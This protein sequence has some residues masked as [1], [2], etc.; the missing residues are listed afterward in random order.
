MTD[1]LC[2]ETNCIWYK[3]EECDAG[4]IVVSCG[5]CRTFQDYI[6]LPEYQCEYWEAIVRKSKKDIA[7]KRNKGKE[8]MVNDVKF[9]TRNNMKWGERC[10]YLTDARTG[11]MVG[12]MKTL[13]ERWDFYIDAI[14]KHRDVMEFPEME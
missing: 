5:E 14:K 9:Y 12:D 13:K 1:I 10:I 11:I 4:K 2:N 8:V 6:D 3:D 7:R